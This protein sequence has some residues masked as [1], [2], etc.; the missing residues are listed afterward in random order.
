MAELS[1]TQKSDADK[2]VQGLKNQYNDLLDGIESEFLVDV[3]MSVVPP[4]EKGF[5]ARSFY[6]ENTKVLHRLRRILSVMPQ[7]TRDV[8]KG[9]RFVPNFNPGS[10]NEGPRV[11]TDK[12][13]E[14]NAT[15]SGGEFVTPDDEL[16]GLI[17]KSLKIPPHRPGQRNPLAV[18]ELAPAQPAAIAEQPAAKVA[19]AETPDE[20]KSE[21][22]PAS[23]DA[24]PSA[25]LVASNVIDAEFRREGDGPATEQELKELLELARIRYSQAKLSSSRFEGIRDVSMKAG[26]KEAQRELDAAEDEYRKANAEFVGSD[27]LKY[28]QEK[29]E[30]TRSHLMEMG[31]LNPDWSTKIGNAVKA[32]QEMSVYNYMKKEGY[33]WVDA[34]KLVRFGTKVLNVKTLVSVGLVAGGFGLAKVGMTGISLGVAVARSGLSGASAMVGTRAYLES[35]RKSWADKELT[36]VEISSLNDLDSVENRIADLEKNAFF[37]GGSFEDIIALPEYALLRARQDELY[38]KYSEPAQRAQVMESRLLDAQQMRDVRIDKERSGRKFTKGAG[39]VVGA[40]MSGFAFYNYLKSPPINPEFGADDPA[41][42]ELKKAPESTLA[43]APDAVRAGG[44]GSRLEEISN[45]ASEVKAKLDQAYAKGAPVAEMGAG[46]IDVTSRGVEGTLLDLKANDPNRYKGM[47]AWLHGK[48]SGMESS[49]GSLV[50][51]AVLEMAG[52]D[53]YTVDGGGA[54]LSAIDSAKIRFAADGSFSMDKSSIDFSGSVDAADSADAV[55]R[56][57][58]GVKFSSE[59]ASSVTDAAETAPDPAGIKPETL[60]LDKRM[61]TQYDGLKEAVGSNMDQR[62]FTELY[63]SVKGRQMGAALRGYMKR[64]YKPFVEK[65]LHATGPDLN[66]IQK[67]SVKEFLGQNVS[68]QSPPNFTERYKGLFEAS[69][70][71]LADATSAQR[72]AMQSESMRK[73]LIRMAQDHLERV[74]K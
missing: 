6:Q 41:E 61:P 69:S 54:D 28:T 43:P 60:D 70:K 50:H 55:T 67:M 53:G 74:K 51:R 17:V 23:T 58:A 33:Q 11:A 66:R 27:S 68:T 47:M 22:H 20:N 26:Y 8:I 13:I 2:D 48:Y 38:S 63:E 14:F 12:R 3:T 10:K 65:F 49:D 52:K 57:L 72:S 29:I 62:R 37:H 32:M 56:K 42:I 24:E 71:Y 73:F 45:E 40:A 9:T 18:D 4:G 39:V 19:P 21:A 35:W 25:T 59:A 7:E 5:N 46:E 30:L 16:I 34:N 15:S 31:K 36:E 1:D 64:E 44:A